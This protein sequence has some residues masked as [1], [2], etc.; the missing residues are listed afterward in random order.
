MDLAPEQNGIRPKKLLSV[1][2]LSRVD[3]CQSERVAK[4]NAKTQPD[5]TGF[6]T[7]SRPRFAKD[8]FRMLFSRAFET[9]ALIGG[10]ALGGTAEA[11]DFQ[12][13]DGFDP[14]Q[15]IILVKGE[16]VPGDDTEFYELTSSAE[17]VIV[18]LESPGGDVETGLSIGS[19]IAMRGFTTLVLEGL[20]SEEL[21]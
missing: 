14:G 15:K 2:A 19:E 18:H 11:A 16:I 9:M 13:M 1:L 12:I 21:V 6:R 3:A 20:A 7:T 8:L 10:L 4:R 17:R 5:E